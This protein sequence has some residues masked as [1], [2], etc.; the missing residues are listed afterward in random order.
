MSTHEI[1]EQIE[2]MAHG[3]GHNSGSARYIGIT[4]ALLG[5]MVAFCSAMVGAQRTELIKAMVEQSTRMGTYQT[6]TMKFRSMSANSALLKALSPAPDEIKKIETT[7]REKRGAAGKKD[8]ED[9]AELKDLIS[10]SVED[11]ADLLTPDRDVIRDFAKVAKV[12][13][14]DMKE[15]KE[16]A[17]SY[18]K[19]IEAR[20]DA[21]EGYERAL[22]AAEIGIVIAS[23]ALLLS[24]RIVWGV[25]LVLAILCVG[26]SGYTFQATRRNVA[27][28]QD[29][30]QKAA[31]NVIQIE[32]DDEEQ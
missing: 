10:S 18:D 27:A 9:T 19:M 15:A 32:K 31:D 2:H 14:R 8:D 1:A 20:Q 30:I 11:L 21:A 4:M 22:L 23:V 7:L 3:G 16:D 17:D 5:V 13:E 12:Y 6:E 28:A 25:S 26:T 24:N 29:K